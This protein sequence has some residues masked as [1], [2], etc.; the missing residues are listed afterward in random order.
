MIP[1]TLAFKMA[2]IFSKDLFD[3]GCV[4]SHFWSGF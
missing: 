3:D 4:V 2:T 1:F